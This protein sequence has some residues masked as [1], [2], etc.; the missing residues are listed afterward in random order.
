MPMFIHQWWKCDICGFEIHPKICNEAFLRPPASYSDR[1]PAV[2]HG[3]MFLH[4]K[5]VCHNHE[6]KIV[7]KEI[8]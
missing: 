5:F 2:P 8:A 7:D 6:A 1:P 3:W 4:G